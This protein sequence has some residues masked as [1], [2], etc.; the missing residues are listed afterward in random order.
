MPE[1]D[2]ACEQR[3]FAVRP[4]PPV[5]YRIRSQANTAK[6]LVENLALMRIRGGL[7]A[8]PR[9]ASPKHGCCGAGD[10]ASMLTA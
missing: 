10:I 4:L 7:D 2:V 6:L 8:A 1:D 9:S 5:Q 3:T